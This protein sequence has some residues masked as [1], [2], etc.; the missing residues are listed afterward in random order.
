V[1]EGGA[2]AAHYLE[3]DAFGLVLELGDIARNENV[4]QRG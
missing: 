4:E 1:Q 3:A 2:C